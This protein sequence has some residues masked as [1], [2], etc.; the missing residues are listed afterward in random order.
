[1]VSLGPLFYTNT[2]NIEYPSHI[3]FIYRSKFS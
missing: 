3:D 2:N 1:M